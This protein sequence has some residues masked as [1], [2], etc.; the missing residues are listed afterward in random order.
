MVIAPTTITSAPPTATTGPNAKKSEPGAYAD[1]F[2]HKREKISEDQI[3]H[4]EKAPEFSE[5]VEDKFRM[6]AMRNCAEAHRHFLNNETDRESED[7]ER[8]EKADA[9]ARAGRGI[10][11]HTRR[12]ILAKKNEDP[13]PNQ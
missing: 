2:C 10:G 8:N 5:T 13:G 9:E 4:G 3:A 7:D 12:V 6:S 1:K 11:K